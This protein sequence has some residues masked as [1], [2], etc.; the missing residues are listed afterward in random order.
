MNMKNLAKF[1]SLLLVFTVLSGNCIALTVGG[2]AAGTGAV[3]AAAEVDG[4][5]GEEGAVKLSLYT[6]DMSAG[7]SAEVKLRL[8]IPEGT[9]VYGVQANLVYDPGSF[10]S[11]S[12][13]SSTG[14]ISFIPGSFNIGSGEKEY[15]AFTLNAKTSITEGYYYVYLNSIKIIDADG[16]EIKY[17]VENSACKFAVHSDV[18]P[19]VYMTVS[20][21]KL[22]LAKGASGSLKLTVTPENILDD[23]RKAEWYSENENIAVVDGEGRVTAVG[24]GEVKIHIKYAPN[25]S[26]I[27]E[28]GDY[29]TVTV[30][31]AS[32]TAAVIESPAVRLNYFVGEE[33]DTSG[34][35]VRIFPDAKTSISV[36]EGFIVS[37]EPFDEP[38]EYTVNVNCSGYSVSYG[39]TVHPEEEKPQ[40][41]FS[42]CSLPAKEAF[43]RS[44][45]LEGRWPDI[46]GFALQNK[47]GIKVYFNRNDASGKWSFSSTGGNLKIG[48]NKAQV[49]FGGYTYNFNFTLKEDDAP[50]SIWVNSPPA[51]SQDFGTPM[52]EM[53]LFGLDVRTETGEKVDTAELVFPSTRL[54]KA[55]NVVSFTY[56]GLT[57][58][59][60]AVVEIPP[61]D[62]ATGIKIAQKPLKTT[63]YSDEEVSLEGLKVAAVYNGAVLQYLDDYTVEE[64]Q[65][66][67]GN[68]TVTVRWGEFSAEFTVTVRSDTT[69]IPTEITSD[70]YTIR[71][72]YIYGIGINQTVEKVLEGI[73]EKT[74]A[75]IKDANGEICGG[76][77]VAATGMKICLINKQTGEQTASVTAVIAGDLNGDGAV[78]DEDVKLMKK[79]LL[80]DIELA[81]AVL[82]AADFDMNGEADISDLMYMRDLAAKA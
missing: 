55:E 22:M 63:Y 24:A 6:A 30:F 39:V 44:E 2:T 71:D 37:H 50:E 13:P 51:Q 11:P 82:S 45:L 33:V 48:L 74:F 69:P 41:E 32:L 57:E 17:K 72:G 81:D 9:E 21:S 77:T 27:Y 62:A 66:R 43:T 47:D 12:D 53:T 15:T 38:G 31:E 56:K 8:S 42:I 18:K 34:L 16:N 52:N 19:D 78:T 28:K 49:I 35:K 1:I 65:Y 20:P 61:L 67:V 80:G 68:N 14:R 79:Y 54:D 7:E 36:T 60:I 76:S 70:I 46:T 23:A 4:S 10:T 3:S 59:F 25:E 5:D 73:N 26:G 75:V 58:Y 64:P 40:A 29:C